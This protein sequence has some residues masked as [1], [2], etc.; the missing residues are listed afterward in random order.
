MKFNPD[1][2]MSV[3]RNYRA[4]FREVYGRDCTISDEKVWHVFDTVFIDDDKDAEEEARVE[5][6]LAL[7]GEGRQP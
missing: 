7:E 4:M 3:V 2:H 1:I 6:M 5:E